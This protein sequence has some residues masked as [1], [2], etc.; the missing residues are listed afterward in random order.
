VYDMTRVNLVAIL[1]GDAGRIHG[2]LGWG[3]G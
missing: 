3:R 1:G 2:R